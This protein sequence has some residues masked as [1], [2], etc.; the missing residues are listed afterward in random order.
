MKWLSIS[1]RLTCD[2]SWTWKN[3]TIMSKT[4]Q[5]FLKGKIT[6]RAKI[7]IETFKLIKF[8]NISLHSRSHEFLP[9][10]LSDVIFVTLCGVWPVVS[11]KYIF[12][13]FFTNRFLLHVHP[14][15]HCGMSSYLQ[16][17]ST[18]HYLWGGVS[19]KTAI[20]ACERHYFLNL[21][22]QTL[23]NKVHDPLSPQPFS[24]TLSMRWSDLNYPDH[25]SRPQPHLS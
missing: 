22:M 24:R 15:A 17:P 18:G 23:R 20:R 19:T 10:L 12:K 25:F 11:K 1:I 3:M 21:V 6:H 8:D 2:D 16:A 9:N 5:F 14:T 13:P 7:C 4:F